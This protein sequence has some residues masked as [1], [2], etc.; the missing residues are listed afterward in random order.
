MKSVILC[1][2]SLLALTLT[3]TPHAQEVTASIPQVQNNVE[4]SVSVMFKTNVTTLNYKPAPSKFPPSPL[5]FS[6]DK[7]WRITVVEKV[8]AVRFPSHPEI[9][10]VFQ[11]TSL[12]SSNVVEIAGRTIQRPVFV[13]VSTN[14]LR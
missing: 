12:V 8:Y 4:C 10:Q 7:R 2:I 3:L 9:Q 14:T 5:A 1:L 13:P 11:G 6:E